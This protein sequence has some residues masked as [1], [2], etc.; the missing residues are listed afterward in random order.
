[1]ARSH[2]SI[3]IVVIFHQFPKQGKIT[4][5]ATMFSIPLLLWL[6]IFVLF[7]HSFWI[8]FMSKHCQYQGFCSQR[9]VCRDSGQ[10]VLIWPQTSF[11]VV[12]LEHSF[13]HCRSKGQ[14]STCR[15]AFTSATWLRSGKINSLCHLSMCKVHLSLQ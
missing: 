8:F 3:H 12:P 13:W 15:Q 1:M 14:D 11:F 4:Y 9:T 7:S 10:R 5:G 2:S 6:N